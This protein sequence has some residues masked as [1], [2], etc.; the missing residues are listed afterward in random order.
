MGILTW[1]LQGWRKLVFRSQRSQLELDIAEELDFHRS[2]KE[3]EN[4][5][6]GLPAEVAAELTR[7]QMGN[8]TL[9]R[10]ESRDMWSFLRFEHLLQDVRYAARM[11]GR[12]PGFSAIAVLSLAIGIGGNA[13]MFTLVNTLL[14]RPLPYRE[15]SRLI[16]VTGFYP[17]AALAFF[18]QSRTMEVASASTGSEFNLTGEGEA[19]RVVGSSTSSNLFAVLGA[20]VAR[21]RAFEPG[22]NSPGRDGVV[23]LSDSLWRSKFASDPRIVGRSITLNGMNRQVVGVMPAALSY[24]SSKTQLWIPV[25]LNPSIMEEYWG[26]EF[27]PLIARLRP[28]AS[29]QQARNE[30]PSLVAKVKRA[31]PFPMKRDWNVDATGILLQQ[32][33]TG[34]VR[35][36]LIILLASV[37]MVLL[38]ACANVANLLLSRAT[39][40][41]KEIAVRVALGA[42][43]ARVI[44]QL[45]T[46]SIMLAFAGSALGLCLGMAGL[47]IFKSLLPAGTPGLMS[48]EIDWSVV[49]FVAGLALLTGVGFG[50]APALSASQIDLAGAMKTGSQKSTAAA[51]TS[52]RSWLIAGEVALTLLLLVG[53]GLL[54]K[55]LYRL[56]QGNPGFDPSRLITVR[57]SPNESSCTQRAACIA[58]YDRI[59]RSASRMAG[60]SEVAVANTVPL[61]GELPIIP[62]D[63]EGH[64]RSADFPS[65]MFWTGAIS[66]GYLRMM[67][68]PLLAGREFSEADGARAAN[69]L[70]ITPE[71]ARRF[72]PGQNPIGKHLRVVFEDQ[73]RTVVGVVGDVRQSSL[74]EGLPDWLGGAMYMPYAQSV[75]GN[76]QIPAA[77]NLLV[78]PSHDSPRLR[79]ELRRLAEDQAPN[80]PVGEVQTLADMMS[81]S[82]GDFRST[83]QVFI[84]FAAA[85]ILLAAVGIYGLVSYWVTQRTYEIGLRVAIGAT[86]Q[87]IV[88]MVLGQGFRL[89]LIGIGGGLVAALALTRFLRSLLYGVTTTDPITFAGVIALLLGMVLLAAAFPAW[90]AARIDPL[91]SLRVD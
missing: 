60:V 24:P 13:A 55:S 15:P 85:A 32:D 47:S 3:R 71:A 68:I 91:K 6:T 25:R 80:A 21:G 61:D 26:G 41:R 8:L 9:A 18:E 23:I 78:K 33:L 44:R 27:T 17:P 22:E 74:A 69:V 4:R 2:L 16:R 64:P 11:F 87:H 37:A 38:I 31:F 40:R 20:P 72:W 43:R 1:L 77:M 35:G 39:T 73:W 79:N 30:I 63:V 84:S 86:R 75:Q 65:P 36:R 57:I 62:V 46:E 50:I 52:L 70:L 88:S 66:P 49:A 45:L 10:E 42:A 76:K 82:I 14:I 83:I 51:W 5:R 81:A 58:L 67:R 54:M 12:A 59:L 56:S 53:A 48:A 34:D 29:L 19:I 7:R 90:R 28:G 89:S